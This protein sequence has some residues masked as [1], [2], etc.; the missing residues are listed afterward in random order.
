MGKYN[1]TGDGIEQ[2]R[3]RSKNGSRNNKENQ[4]GD[5]SGYRNPR[6]EIRNHR[7]TTEYKI[8]R[9]SQM[10]KTQY[11][12]WTEQSMQMQNAKKIVLKLK[13]KSSTQ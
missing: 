1:Q 12:T 10:E 4:K 6:K 9:E 5:N 3:P 11:R 7:S 2:N 13:R 8:W